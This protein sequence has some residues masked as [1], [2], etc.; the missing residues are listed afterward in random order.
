M[1][2]ALLIAL[3]LTSASANAAKPEALC[4]EVTKFHKAT[5]D[6]TVKPKGRRWVELHWI[7]S[8]MDFDHGWGLGCRHSPDRASSNLCEWLTRHTSY[9]FS[10]LAPE[11][12][13]TCYGYKFLPNNHWGNWKSDIDL[14]DD[15]RWLKLEIDFATLNG[16]TGAVRISSFAKDQEDA[17]VELPSLKPWTVEA[18]SGADPQPPHAPR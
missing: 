4:A 5:F 13:L 8:W 9:E 18:R 2:K 11:H 12:L 15:D 14:F 3:S 16:E 7:G 17:L 1:K 6:D 10:Q